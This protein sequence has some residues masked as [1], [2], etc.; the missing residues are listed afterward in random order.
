MKTFLL[1]LT[2]ILVT[3]LFWRDNMKFIFK[4][5]WLYNPLTVQVFD[6]FVVVAF[7]IIMFGVKNGN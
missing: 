4:Y 2:S 1:H 7:L 6:F 5:P 3:M